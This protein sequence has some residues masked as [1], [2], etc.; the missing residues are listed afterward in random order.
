MSSMLDLASREQSARGAGSNTETITWT[1]PDPSYTAAGQALIRAGR[2][3][4]FAWLD[5]VKAAAGCTRPIRL[6]GS[7]STVESGTG[8]LLGERHTDELPD[9][10]IY[11]ACGNRRASVCPSRARTYQRDAYQLLR[12][13][14]VGGKEIGRAHV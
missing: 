9:A 1:A 4:Y 2:P 12:A 6:S 14:L 3:D 5:H 10:A 11:K 13:G 7:V 8:R